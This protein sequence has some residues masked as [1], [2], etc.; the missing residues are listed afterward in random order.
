MESSMIKSSSNNLESMF[1]YLKIVHCLSKLFDKHVVPQDK[2]GQQSH[3]GFQ[4]LELKVLCTGKENTRQY[5]CF[6]QTS[7]M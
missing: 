1:P 4:L 2:S 6:I 3:G 5:L 7:E